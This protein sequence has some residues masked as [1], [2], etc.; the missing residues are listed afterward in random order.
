M[1]TVQ[2]SP[3]GHHP[4]SPPCSIGNPAEPN[5]ADLPTD[6]ANN[7]P[8]PIPNPSYVHID[9]NQ[10]PDRCQFTFSDGRQC[11]MA[12]SDIHPSLCR[13]HSEREEQ[14]FG[15]PAPG[16]NVVGRALDLPELH[17]A[18][19]DL[20][21]AAGV[22]RALGQVFRLLA[23]RRISR[24][25]AATFGYLAQLLLQ[26]I[27]PARMD[28]PSEQRESRDL[29]ASARGNK[30]TAAAGP[31]SDSSGLRPHAAGPVD[32][33]PAP[34]ADSSREATEGR[35]LSAPEPSTAV[36]SSSEPEIPA[37]ACEPTPIPRTP[38]PASTA[39]AANVMDIRSFAALN[40]EPFAASDPIAR[41][42][43]TINTSAA[44]VSNSSEINTSENAES[45]ALQNEHLQKSGP[46]GHRRERHPRRERLPTG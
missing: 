15:D 23:Q 9:T 28:V 25:E 37:A 16:G 27:R 20:T 4:L 5:R 18:C 43:R 13:F 19:R 30:V 31:H 41:N 11:A 36:N 32:V 46:G 45:E 29:S 3:N 26:T 17:S 24:Q 21:T 8:N 2:E 35:T 42:P 40:K 34:R 12:R 39:T 14:L 1:T 44:F 33:P 7:I 6:K 22:N 38:S 10:L